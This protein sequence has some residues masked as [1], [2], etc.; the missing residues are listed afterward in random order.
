MGAKMDATNRNGLSL[1]VLES[2][3]VYLSNI[4]TLR[5]DV[6]VS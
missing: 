5:D 4:V 1:N 3:P 2:D 6:L